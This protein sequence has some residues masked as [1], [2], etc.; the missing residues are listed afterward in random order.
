M[1]ISTDAKKTIS[2]LKSK[3]RTNVSFD[4]IFRDININGREAGMFFIDG[5][6]KDEVMEK[7]MEFFY[8]LKSDDDFKN[9]ET[10]IKNCIPYIEV[11]CSKDIN[12]ASTN[13]LSG[14]LAIVIDK[15]DKIILL[16]VRTY[17]QRETQE[18]EKDKVLRG[19]RDGFVETLIS[20]TALIRRR[21]R[22]TNLSM[23]LINVGSI[24]KTDVVLCYMEDKVDKKLLSSITER[25]SSLNVDSLTMNQQ[26]LAEALFKNKWYNPF[27][28]IKH[29]E[30]PDTA[31]SAVLE[32]NIVIL[33]DN[34]PSVSIIPTSIF[35]ILEEADDYYFPPLTE[36]SSDYYTPYISPTIETFDIDGFAKFLG[37]NI[38]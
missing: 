36:I 37:V 24:S 21:I 6:T 26:S 3:L 11:A 19:S 4:I 8:S 22:N 28:K 30:R 15:L 29:S 35:D 13:I 27:P 2:E 38:S 9:C 12:S 23:K 34:S 1:A 17:P 25:I 5:F 14:M 32:G 18:P 20:N 31:A 10:F 7:I 33:V 16:D